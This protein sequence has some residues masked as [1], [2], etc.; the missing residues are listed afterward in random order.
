MIHNFRHSC[1]ALL[2]DSDANIRLVAKY[3]GYST[4]D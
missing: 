1:A 3:L 4:I 2:I